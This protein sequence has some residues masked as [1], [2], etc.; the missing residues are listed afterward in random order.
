MGSNNPDD[1]EDGGNLPEPVDAEPESLSRL[2]EAIRDLDGPM[3]ISNA[4]VPREARSISSEEYPADEEP[5]PRPED[6]D[7]V[8]RSVATARVTRDS[9]DQWKMWV[10]E[11]D[12]RIVC[13]DDTFVED[14]RRFA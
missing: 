8:H 11:G 1:S 14:L 7:H 5:N 10:D 6:L 12:T 2:R 4:G 3:S 13:D 9:G